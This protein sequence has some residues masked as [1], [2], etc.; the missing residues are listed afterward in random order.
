MLKH[1]FCQVLPGI[2]RVSSQ[3]PH[4]RSLGP[5]PNIIGSEKG[6]EK[7]KYVSYRKSQRDTTAPLPKL[8]QAKTTAKAGL[9]NPPTMLKHEVPIARYRT[10]QI[11]GTGLFKPGTGLLNPVLGLLNPVL[12]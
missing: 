12:G 10:T 11:P 6:P 9:I 8:K 7:A 3:G 2:Y 4:A 1:G 5:K